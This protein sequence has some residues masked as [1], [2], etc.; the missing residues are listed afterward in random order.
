M[1][2]VVWQPLE[3]KSRRKL[4]SVRE[5][6]GVLLFNCHKTTGKKTL[7]ILTRAV[8]NPATKCAMGQTLFFMRALTCHRGTL[9]QNSPILEERASISQVAV[10]L[11]DSSLR[12]N[13]AAINPARFTTLSYI[14]LEALQHNLSSAL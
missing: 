10:S 9:C 14:T 1:Q 6:N 12:R 7:F 3:K 13:V 11:F 5:E 8:K 4:I 2:I